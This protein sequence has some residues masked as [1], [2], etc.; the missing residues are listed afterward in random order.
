MRNLKTV[1]ALTLP[2]ALL[3]APASSADAD[4]YRHRY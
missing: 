2:A 1:G 3:A 4:W